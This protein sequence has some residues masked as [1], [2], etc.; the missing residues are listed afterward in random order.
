MLEAMKKQEDG[1]III[2]GFLDVGANY[3]L[4]ITVLP[5]TNC[6]SSFTLIMKQ[7]YMGNH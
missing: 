7:K 4:E 2:E 6:S 3:R 1:K 5:I